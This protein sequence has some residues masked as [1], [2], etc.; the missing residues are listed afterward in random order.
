MVR[1]GATFITRLS[2]V[3]LSHELCDRGCEVSAFRT[4]TQSRH[5]FGAVELDPNFSPLPVIRKVHWTIPEQVLILEVD[6]DLPAYVL[7]CANKLGE[8]R[9]SSRYVC[10]TLQYDLATVAVKVVVIDNA[11][12]VNQYIMLH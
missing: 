3:F 5:G 2:R 4:D 8:K 12:A 9:S 1:I 7:Q 6:G 11:D 10:K